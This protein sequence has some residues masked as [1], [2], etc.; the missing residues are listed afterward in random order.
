MRQHVTSPL[1]TGTER[2][3]TLDLL[4]SNTQTPISSVAVL[5]GIRDHDIVVGNIKCSLKKRTNI[6]PQKVYFYFRGDYASMAEERFVYFAEFEALSYCHDI[7]AMSGL[8]KHK[9]ILP[10]ETYVPSK[11]LSKSIKK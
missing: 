4:S 5:L 1:R 10:T 8:F 7:E 11:L 2:V 3:S 9:L 6:P